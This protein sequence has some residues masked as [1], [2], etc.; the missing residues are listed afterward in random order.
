MVVLGY[1][2]VGGLVKD[3]GIG[4]GVAFNML[5]LNPGVENS[6][7]LANIYDLPGIVISKP[8]QNP[9]SLYENRGLSIQ[10]MVSPS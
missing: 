5:G 9:I 8:Y 1:A 2:V 10:F 7:Y 3:A 6:R 4:E